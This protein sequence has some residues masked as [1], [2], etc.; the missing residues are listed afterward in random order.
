MI[1]L[2]NQYNSYLINY[3]TELLKSTDVVSKTETRF[4]EIKILHWPNYVVH[5]RQIIQRNSI[6]GLRLKNLK[7]RN[8]FEDFIIIYF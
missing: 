5:E 4:W 6:M 7:I 1:K 8:H 2:Q 3:C